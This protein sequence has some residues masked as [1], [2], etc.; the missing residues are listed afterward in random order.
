MEETLHCEMVSTSLSCLKWRKEKFNGG[1]D[2]AWLRLFAFALWLTAEFN[3]AT[4]KWANS[5]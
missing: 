2:F 4:G 5:E 3:R 1:L